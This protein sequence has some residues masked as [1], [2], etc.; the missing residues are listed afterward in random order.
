M[1][2]DERQEMDSLRARLSEA[3]RL[4]ADPDER[5]LAAGM[6]LDQ[7]GSYLIVRD[8]MRVELGLQGSDLFVYAVL[9]GFTRHGRPFVGGTR[10]LES[11]SG[12]SKRSVMRSLANLQSLGLVEATRNPT[13]R[14]KLLYSVDLNASLRAVNMAQ[15]GDNGLTGT[16]NQTYPEPAP[17][18]PLFGSVENSGVEPLTD[19]EN[20]GVINK[21]RTPDWCQNGTEHLIGAKMAPNRCQNGTNPNNLLIVNIKYKG[22][23]D[24]RARNRRDCRK[25]SPQSQAKSQAAPSIAEVRSLVEDEGLALDAEAFW[26]TM[27]EAGWRDP[28]GAPI[29]DW[30]RLARSWSKGSARPRRRTR[31]DI[32]PMSDEEAQRIDRERYGFDL[33]PVPEGKVRI[34]L[35]GTS[36]TLDRDEDP[37][38]A[39]ERA[40]AAGPELEPV[41]WDAIRGAYAKD[42]DGGAS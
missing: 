10:Y 31:A 25:P 23:G 8:W 18:S 3:E 32:V 40:F 26:R 19:V 39:F 35:N 9:F 38:A 21:N 36:L 20:L 12:F 6:E 4:L 15:S 37:F 41:W 7:T 24:T 30:H 29:R 13:D 11:V 22:G 14:K 17:E 33:S 5:A 2:D 27:G 42:G 34:S 28:S 1:R 16:G